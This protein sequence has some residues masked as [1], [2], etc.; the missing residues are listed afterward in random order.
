MN[1][2]KTI[3]NN[4][5]LRPLNIT[6]ILFL[7]FISIFS[8]K[9][10]DEFLDIKSKLSDV[11]PTTLPDF[12]ALLD[13]ESIMI[14]SRPSISLI[15]SG[16]LYLTDADYAAQ[17][18]YE[19]AAYRW[20]PNTWQ[21]QT[22]TDWT[23]SYQAI[24]YANVVLDG[25]QKLNPAESNYNSIKGSALFHRAY[26]L[27]NLA[28]LFCK[29]FTVSTADTD[30]GIPIRLS[31]DI[32]I[33]SSRGTV[34]D[35]YDRIIN[36]LKAALLLLPPSQLYKTRPDQNAGNF[37]LAKVYLSM[38]DYDNALK[39][40]NAALAINS[41]LLDFNN[42][43]LV[44]LTATY[45]FP[46]YVKGNPE[47]IFYSS[48]ILY[49]PSSPSTASS[50]QV[51]SIL[52][53]LYDAN[54]LRKLYFF[55]SNGSG[56]VKFQGSYTGANSNFSG[57][58]N[59]EIY[60][61]RA[62]CY[63]RQGKTTEA[64]ADLNALLSK[65]WITGTFTPLVASDTD[66]ALKLILQERRKE[67]CFT[68]NVRWEDLRRLNKDPRFATTLTRVINSVTYTLAPNDKKYVFPIPDAEI[69]L[70][71]MPQNER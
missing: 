38:E 16:N 17:S 65:R 39:Y 55:K 23:R 59:N 9:K 18:T 48:G 2:I 40:A 69:Q 43:N 21:G 19:R 51:D 66:N 63:A 30:P 71:G 20:D 54:D 8:C 64:M 14:V 29:P 56:R 44:N 12:Q 61:I 68:P 5:Q 27:Y 52:Y 53:K 24:G 7:I 35:V 34:Q 67:L 62:E 6:L 60:L 70:T 37:L 28:S 58:A 22:S 33:K 13:N 31:S 1:N 57:M 41:T 4:Q 36:D 11:T 47:I 26:N 49:I 46:T 45:R 10:Q 15:S 3:T 32:N 25:I 42:N 50:G